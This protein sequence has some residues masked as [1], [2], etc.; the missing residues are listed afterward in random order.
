MQLALHHCALQLHVLV[1]VILKLLTLSG[2]DYRDLLIALMRDDISLA[3]ITTKPR[4]DNANCKFY[5]EP[6]DHFRYIKIQHRSEA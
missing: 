4:F 3:K 5:R 1:G 6:I 2:E